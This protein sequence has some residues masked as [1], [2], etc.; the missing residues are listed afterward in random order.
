M[1]SWTALLTNLL[2]LKRAV[3]TAQQPLALEARF[4][5]SPRGTQGVSGA[6]RQGGTETYMGEVRLSGLRLTR[7]KR[8]S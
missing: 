4:Y 8:A 6:D 2:G 3:H 5:F 1:F 7:E